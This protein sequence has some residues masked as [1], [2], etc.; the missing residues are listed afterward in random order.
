VVVLWVQRFEQTGS[1]AA[2]PSG[3]STS[4]LEEHAGFLLGLITEQPDLTLDELVAAMRKRGIP[5]CGLAVLRS[6]RHQPQKKPCTLRSKSAR[7][8]LAS[9]EV[10]IGSDRS[11]RRK[12]ALSSAVLARPQSDR[13]GHQQSE[14]SPALG[15]RAHHSASIAPD[16][17]DRGRFLGKRVQ[18]LLSPCRLCS[19]L[20]GIRSKTSKSTQTAVA[21]QV[22]SIEA[23]N[24]L[25]HADRPDGQ[26][27]DD[28]RDELQQHA[29]LHQL[30]RAM[31]R[32][33]ARHV[34]QSDQ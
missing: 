4:P 16:R 21:Y 10:W 33:A 28:D 30:L 22:N 3:G 31:G 14:G 11:G 13:A 9:A 12:A 1:V 20:S 25:V 7:R 18:E 6:A 34:G 29:K 17:T 26:H 24:L 5:E 23:A 27:Y 19:N 15:L 8:L 2:R 32:A